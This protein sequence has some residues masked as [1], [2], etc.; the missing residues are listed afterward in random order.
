[1]SHIPQRPFSVDMNEYPFKS[2]WFE[3]DGTFMHY[4]DEG[5]GLPV[6]LFHGNPTWSFLYRKVI[7]QLDGTCRAIAPDYP[8]FGMSQHPIDYGY[9]PE[10]HAGWVRH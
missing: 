4:L 9:T 7:K 5:E 3:Q 8:G 10:E 1:M 2:H 6:L